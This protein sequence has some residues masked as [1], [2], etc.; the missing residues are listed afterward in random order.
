MPSKHSIFQI[1]IS[2]LGIKPPIWRRFQVSSDITL[3]YLHEILQVVMGWKNCHLYQFEIGEEYFGEPHTDYDYE[4]MDASEVKLS[5]IFPGEGAKFIYE[6]DFGDCWD[7]EVKMEKIL[8]LE[9]GKHYP[10]C[11][12]GERACAPEDCGGIWGY[13]YLLKTIW[14][15]EHDEYE[16]MMEWLGGGFDPEEFDLDAINRRLSKIK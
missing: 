4:M 11:L 5:E 12:G 8:P 7:H 6:Y 3:A 16:E 14:N 10:V 15:P 2:L 9:E 1:K 13:D